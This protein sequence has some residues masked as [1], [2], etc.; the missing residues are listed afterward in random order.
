MDFRAATGG[1]LLEKNKRGR[2]VWR[3]R[4]MKRMRGGISDLLGGNRRDIGDLPFRASGHSRTFPAKGG[5]TGELGWLGELKKIGCI[6]YLR[7]GSATAL[8][9]CVPKCNLGT[10]EWGGGSFLR[11]SRAR[12]TSS[13][14]HGGKK[15]ARGF[16]PRAFFGGTAAGTAAATI[17]TSSWRRRDGSPLRRGRRRLPSSRALRRA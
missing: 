2:V 1:Q 12:A 7:R 17:V 11:A 8:D 4:R 9:K 10:R 13:P 14:G 15:N 16:G 6:G 3:V 5:S